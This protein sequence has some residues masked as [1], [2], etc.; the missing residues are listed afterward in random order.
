MKKIICTIL[1]AAAACTAAV[2][3][4]AAGAHEGPSTTVHTAD[5]NLASESGMA[6]FRG[7]VKAAANRLC[8]ADR[9]APFDYETRAIAACRTQVFSSAQ[10]QLGLTLAARAEVGVAGTR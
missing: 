9:S 4:Y 7:R 3:A 6:T 10:A 5:L 2:P 8:G 1:A